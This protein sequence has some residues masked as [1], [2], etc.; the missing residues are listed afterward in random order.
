M[1]ETD[2]ELIEL[3]AK[4]AGIELTDWSEIEQ[5]Y[6]RKDGGYFR[7]LTD[8]GDALRLAVRLRLHFATLDYSAIASEDKSGAFEQEPFEGSD[9]YAAT[10]RA[11]VRAAASIGELEKVAAAARI[12]TQFL[13]GSLSRAE[14]AKALAEIFGPEVP[15]K[16]Q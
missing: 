3:A 15:V 12:E 11:I 8:D 10:R 2:R 16:E 6:R 4:A 14:A 7:A 9:P 5:A 1:T 13:N